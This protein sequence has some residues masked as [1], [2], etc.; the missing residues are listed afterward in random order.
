[1]SIEMTD[2]TRSDEEVIST[3]NTSAALSRRSHLVDWLPRS[4]GNCLMLVLF[5]L[6]VPVLMQLLWESVYT[7]LVVVIWPVL[8]Y[9]NY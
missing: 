5:V 7:P 2:L 1:M 9:L 6:A 4:I 8:C 3:P